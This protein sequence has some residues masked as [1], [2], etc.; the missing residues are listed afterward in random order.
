MVPMHIPEKGL[1]LHG[2]SPSSSTDTA[3]GVETQPQVMRLDLA[4][5]VL[6]DIVRASKI[7]KDVHMSFGK[8]LVRSMS[9]C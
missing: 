2:H 7:G 1:V 3:V 9:Y 4:S 6:E 5:G 8:N